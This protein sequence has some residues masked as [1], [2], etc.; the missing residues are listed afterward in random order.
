MAQVEDVGAGRRR[1]WERLALQ[2]RIP[3]GAGRIEKRSEFQRQRVAQHAP[4][5]FAR[6]L[7]ALQI[8]I[9]RIDHQRRIFGLPGFGRGS[10]QQVLER[11]GGQ[12]GEAG[13]DSSGVGGDQI[14]LFRRRGCQYVLGA[15]AKAVQAVSAIQI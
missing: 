12:R 2:R 5:R 13:V 7:L 8:Q 6:P 4:R 15:V 11:W 1:R 14:P 9:H 10:Q 3:V